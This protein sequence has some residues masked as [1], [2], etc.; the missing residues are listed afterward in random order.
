MTR[1]SIRVAHDNRKVTDP[2]SAAIDGTFV[3]GRPE[4]AARQFS[5]GTNAPGSREVDI[6]RSIVSRPSGR[7]FST[8]A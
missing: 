8:W 3:G 4:N 2:Y 5:R 7:R 6:L 1:R